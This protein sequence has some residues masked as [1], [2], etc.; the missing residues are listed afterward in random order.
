MNSDKGGDRAGFLRSRVSAIYA[1]WLA[2]FVISFACGGYTLGFLVDFESIGTSDDPNVI[3]AA[4]NWSN[5]DLGNTDSSETID[6]TGSSDVVLGNTDDADSP[7]ANSGTTDDTDPSVANLG[8]TESDTTNSLT[9]CDSNSV[10]RLFSVGSWDR[11]AMSLIKQT[12]ET[13]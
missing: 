3:Q 2:I 11:V 9:A 7:I 6:N 4:A 5:A 13:P 8:N 10:C 12:I 1:V